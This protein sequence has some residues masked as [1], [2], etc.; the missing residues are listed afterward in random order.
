MKIVHT[1][2]NGYEITVVFSHSEMRVF[3][4]VS[5]VKM[6]DKKFDE[7]LFSNLQ[8]LLEIRGSIQSSISRLR[9]TIANLEMIA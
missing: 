3:E 8:T 2:N 6:A 4:E 9:N 7:R 5:K 1:S